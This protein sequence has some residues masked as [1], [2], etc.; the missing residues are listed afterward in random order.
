MSWLNYTGE[1]LMKR[2]IFAL[3]ILLATPLLAQTLA[4]QHEPLAGTRVWRGGVGVNAAD[5]VVDTTTWGNVYGYDTFVVKT[6]AGA[7]D[8]FVS[9]NLN[10][11]TNTCEAFETA[12]H[13]MADLNAVDTEPVVVTAANR[14]YGFRGAF[15]GI[16]V[17]Q[18]GATAATGVVLVA[19]RNY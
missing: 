11:T 19:K 10:A 3:L 13:G 12:A 14:T 5:L 15:C 9:L 17:Y 2:F 18:N 8:V 1:F 16:R 6:T 4:T 7:V